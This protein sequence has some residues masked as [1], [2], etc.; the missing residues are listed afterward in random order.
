MQNN[1]KSKSREPESAPDRYARLKKRISTLN[2]KIAPDVIPR[3]VPFLIYMV[4]LVVVDVLSKVVG[5]GWDLRWLYAVKIALV[6]SVLFLFRDKYQELK[7]TLPLAQKIGVEQLVLALLSGC[8]VFIAWIHLDFDWM[9]LGSGPLFN[10]VTHGD[11][12]VPLMLIRLAG[13]TLVVPLMEELFWR[14]FL[15]RWLDSSDF[16]R[17]DPAE[18]SQRSFLIVVLLF[19]FEHNLWFAGMM[20]AIVYN[21]IY[22]YTK[23]LWLPIISHAVTNGLLGLWVVTT[24][25]WKFW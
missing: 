21:L 13:A 6:A 9:V 23:N 5:S 11:I 18:I 2:L 15:L 1:F 4:G 19:G 17:L 16:T 3:V 7:L 14:S 24:G 8:V 25:N 20:A 10:P 12:D 22:I